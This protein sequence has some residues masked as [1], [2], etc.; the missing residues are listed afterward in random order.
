[1]QPSFVAPPVPAQ[2]RGFGAL[3]G[4]VL[5]RPGGRRALSALSIV[6]FIAGVAMFAYPVGTDAFSRYRQGNLGDQFGS[7]QLAQDYRDNT[8]EVGSVLTR[9]RIPKKGI[10]LDVLVVEGTN[11]PALRAGAGH[12]V[13]TPLPG[14]VGNVA[15]AG[16]RTTFGRPFNRLDE[17]KPGDKV[18]LETPFKIFH[19][20]VV[21][22]FDGHPNPWVVSPTQSSVL[23]NTPGRSMLTLT[24]CH[25]K[26]S[27]RQRLILRLELDPK[28]TEDIHQK[29]GTS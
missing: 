3:L 27:A 13:G 16:H 17:M 2:P 5:R 22:G 6:L 18:I 29:G 12:Y 1:M 15:I 7:T 28:L 24:T 10:N 11:A 23:A 26:G 9:L 19:Y 14:Q 20:V 4:D 8:V 21:P 25:P